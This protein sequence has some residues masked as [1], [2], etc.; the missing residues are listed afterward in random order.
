MT[1]M[2]KRNPEKSDLTKYLVIIGVVLIV[3]VLLAA[4][5]PGD[6][7]SPAVSSTPTTDLATPIA[8][9]TPPESLEERFNRI[10]LAREPV[11]AFFHSNNCKLCLDMIDV[12]DA[13]FPEYAGRIELVDVNVY[14]EQNRNLLLRAKIHSIP[15]QIFISG[16]G[17]A[18]QS[19][20]VMTPDQ[21][22]EVLDKIAGD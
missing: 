1:R 13:V 17:E 15:T 9:L 7:F 4:K 14:D 2:H 20:G 8:T 19:V 11:F 5:N 6:D 3:V 12:V 22:R 21:L 10:L 18:F 16:T